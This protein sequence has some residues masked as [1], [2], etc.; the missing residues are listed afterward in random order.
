MQSALN[1]GS[2]S[3]LGGGRGTSH[4]VSHKNSSCDFLPLSELRESKSQTSGTGPGAPESHT[5]TL[6]LDP[7]HT[8]LLVP[9][10]LS[11]N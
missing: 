1:W 11:R 2:L 4:G 6:L 7:G 5:Q 8:Y 3:M 9:T 10:G